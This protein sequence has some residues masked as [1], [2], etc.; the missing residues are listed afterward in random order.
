VTGGATGIGAAI[1]LRLLAE[2]LDVYVVQRTE[3]DVVAGEQVFGQSNRVC[4]GA[5][6]LSDAK[7]C[8]RAVEACAAHFGGSDV[9]VNNAGVTGAAAVGALGNFTD[10]RIG[11]VTDVNL[12]APLPSSWPHSS[13]F[14]S[15][16]PV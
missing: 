2:G 15:L 13:G 3:A 9:L 8:P 1:T 5:H 14:W 4:L 12:K 10:Q 11:Q 7:E 6:D 16:G